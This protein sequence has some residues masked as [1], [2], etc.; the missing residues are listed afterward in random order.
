MDSVRPLDP[1]GVE[2]DFGMAAAAPD[3]LRRLFDEQGLVLM[4]GLSLSMEEQKDLCR[5]FGPVLDSPHENF[6]VSNVRDDGY[7]G[8]QELLFHNDLS[9]L[10]APYL[11]G[12]LHALEA[13]D[14]ATTTRFASGT[15]AWR[16]L[17]AALR[18]KVEGRNALHVKFRVFDRP[19]RLA[20]L[21]PGDLCT[22]HAVAGRHH[23]TGEDYLM[24]S[25]GITACIAGMSE[26]ESDDLLRQL[27]AHLYAPENVYEHSW[28]V[29]DVIVWDN[30]AIQHARG[31]LSAAPRTL[32]RVSIAR[33]G[34]AE[35][36]PTDLGI[37]GAQYAETLGAGAGL[38]G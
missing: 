32:Q 18:R 4:R 20:D 1:F 30:L 38:A 9:Y 3:A 34:Y 27:Y 17:P 22:V 26:A 12:A 13:G 35:M 6:L 8:V 16:T 5:V 10:P 14:G 7:L 31:P 19:N 21:A 25:E 33:I 37:F 23:R 28:R 2:A 24:V 15:R 11:G 36:Y 29:G